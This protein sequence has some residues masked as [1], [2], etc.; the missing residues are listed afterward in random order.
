MENL[1]GQK[2]GRLTV[3][4]QFRKNNHSYC[5]CQCQC[6]N[7]KDVRQDS[8]K[9]GAIVSCGCYRDERAKR[10]YI[11]ITGKTFG[12]W[13]VLS[14]AARPNTTTNGGTYWLCRC[15]CGVE[16]VVWGNSL[17]NGT[18][19]SC[20]CSKKIKIPFDLAGEQFG[21]LTVLR[22]DDTKE[23]GRGNFWICRCAC[24]KEVVVR[25]HSLVSGHTKSCGCLI[26][27]GEMKIGQF[28]S[29]LGLE[30][31]MQYSFDDLVDK[32]KLRFDFAVFSE[33][34][35]FCLIEVQGRQHFE[36]DKTGNG[37]NTLEHL[38]GVQKHDKMKV[39]Y[40]NAHNIR[41]ILLTTNEIKDMTLKQFKEELLNAK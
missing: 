11:D 35:L 7:K 37:W 28:L 16:R 13:T 17:R 4:S 30:Y 18:S 34:K 41:L 21:R 22:R 14:R 3:L 36:Y 39:G 38:E 26:S 12:R 10:K 23:P 20:G 1:V 29:Q 33:N 40:C 32:G 2:F 24:G 27:F 31:K 5:S 19:T 15:S 6:G 8:L 9:N 25:T